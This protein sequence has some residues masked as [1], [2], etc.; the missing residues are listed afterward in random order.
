MTCPF[1]LIMFALPSSPDKA[2]GS[3]LTAVTANDVDT[4]PTLSYT[5]LEGFASDTFNIDQFSG[6]ILLKRP[7]DYETTKQ[8]RLNIAASDMLHTAQTVLTLNVVDYNDNTPVFSQHY[9][10]ATIPGKDNFSNVL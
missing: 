1:L 8:Y 9:Y 6:K 2:V 4:S 10:Q 3:V 7:L 5:L